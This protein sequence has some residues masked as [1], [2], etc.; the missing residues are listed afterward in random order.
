MLCNWHLEPG[1]VPEQEVGGPVCGK[2]VGNWWFLG[3]LPT[4]IILCNSFRQGGPKTFSLLFLMWH[5]VS[6]THS[7]GVILD[8]WLPFISLGIQ[9]Q[10]FGPTDLP[11]I[12]MKR[13]VKQVS[14]GLQWFAKDCRK[15]QHVFKMDVVFWSR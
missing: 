14:K 10:N 11:R 8:P 6:S 9:L 5:R 4:Q 13:K 3:F 2:G 1:L 7:Q 15:R 12:K